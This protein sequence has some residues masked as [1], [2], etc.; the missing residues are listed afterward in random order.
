MSS[1]ASQSIG[2]F[3]TS[4]KEDFQ[5]NIENNTPFIY[6][7][8]DH[9]VERARAKSQ[10]K[11]ATIANN[12]YKFTNRERDAKTKYYVN[13]VENIQQGNEPEFNIEE[14]NKEA[15]RTRKNSLQTEKLRF[16]ID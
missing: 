1:F 5:N 16:C 2:N 15:N 4:K 9:Q 13:Y 10:K 7:N 8:K 11:D 14:E 12:I 6:T 3:K